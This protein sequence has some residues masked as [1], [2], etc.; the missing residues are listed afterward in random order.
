MSDIHFGTDGWRAIIADT[1]TFR[2]VERVAYAVGKYV[3]GTYHT[4]GAN[5]VPLLISHDTR[6]LA[7]KFA[8]R[9]AQ[10][11]IGMGV[12]VKLVKRD[13]PTP[14]I[15]WATQHEPTA[16]ALQFTASHNPPEYCGIKYI[17]DYAGPAT[18]EITN[19]LLAHLEDL[20][21]D[22]EAP[23]V[24]VPYFDAM[25]PYMEAL[26]KLVD[27]KRIGASGLKIG[28]D[29]LF[30]TSRGYLDTFL[31]E[32]GLKEVHT[33]H[34]WRDPLFGGFMPEPKKEFLVQ[35]SELV[36]TKKLD[37]GIAT[38]GDADRFAVID[39]TGNYFSP[40]QLLCLLTMHLV[41]NRGFKGA[42]VRTVA[43]THLLDRLAQIYGLDLIETPVGFKYVGECMRKGDVLLGGEE[44]GGFSFKLH[45][46]E[47]DGILANLLLI[48]LMAYEKKPLSKI[49]SDLIAEAGIALAYR[50]A[51]LNLPKTQKALMERLISQPLTTLGGE[52]IARI[53]TK[54]GMKLYLDE[55]NWFLIRPSGT[56]PLI[57]LYAEASSPERAD[58]MMSDFNAQIEEI[59]KT[60]Q[61]RTVTN[62]STVPVGST[63]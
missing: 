51:D 7:D 22:Y 37:V 33:L 15:A 31:K 47:K 27:Y 36:K 52:P 28:Y 29:A 59:L 48:E 23:H 55:N 20:P 34:D 41:K 26:K 43:T 53:S 50:R 2:N 3:K 17:P 21:A 11:L 54:D 30:S 10:V 18:T 12:P 24:E 25:P 38:D 61:P 9:A 4:E 40:N 32:S 42:I 62:G 46:P 13:T 14:T 44:S 49:W 1:F 39:E 19:S 16:G 60:I 58:R 6:F 45:I 57:R 5:K 56:E 8:F 35:L 63:H